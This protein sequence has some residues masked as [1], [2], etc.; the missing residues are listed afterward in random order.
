MSIDPANNGLGLDAV[1]ETALFKRRARKRLS[2][3]EVAPDAFMGGTS[4]SMYFVGQLYAYPG[5]RDQWSSLTD[6]SARIDELGFGQSWV[7]PVSS[8]PP[9]D[10]RF[11]SWCHDRFLHVRSGESRGASLALV[12]VSEARVY[13]WKE[14]SDLDYTGF[15]IDMTLGEDG[16]RQ[17]LEYVGA[18]ASGQPGEPLHNWTF[19]LRLP[20]KPFPFPALRG[21][22]DPWSM[23]DR[24]VKKLK[25]I[26]RFK[27]DE[28]TVAVIDHQN[29][30]ARLPPETALCERY[31]ILS[32]IAFSMVRS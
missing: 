27:I 16:L 26:K 14:R 25:T 13:D 11:D 24:C 18:P 4:P 5:L 3:Q 22:S 17:L 7:S 1:A 30:S 23:R 32:A 21:N 12:E 19:V 15:R 6:F 9:K 29:S 10:S 2:V 31:K 20:S 28:F 8:M